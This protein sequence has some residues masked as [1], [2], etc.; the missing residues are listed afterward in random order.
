MPCAFNILANL[1]QSSTFT[2]IIDSST[3]NS[4]Y[5]LSNP[6]L[7][8]FREG[9]IFR[10]YYQSLTDNNPIQLLVGNIENI[11]ISY[12]L[13]GCIISF[14]VGYMTNILSR[15]QLV[16]T[17]SQQQITG[18]L[19]T[20]YAPQQVVF[21]DFLGELLSETYISQ[22]VGNT[23]YYGGQDE[24]IASGK[25]SPSN[26]TATSGSAINA[27]SYV[28]A[29]TPPTDSKLSVIL[30]ILY[31]YQRVIYVNTDGD[32]IIT[33]LTTFFDTNEDWT[34]GINGEP[35]IIP[36]LDISVSKNTTVIQN[37]SYC[38]MNQLFQQ[39]NQS[40]SSSVSN[41]ANTAVC[42]A[43]PP[44]DLFP[45]A[46]DFVQSALGL[47]TSFVIQAFDANAFMQNSGLLNTAYNLTTLSGVKSVL[48][49]NNENIG[50]DSNTPQNPLKYAMSL[51][52]VRDLAQ[53][54]VNDLLVDIDINTT[55]TYS[56]VLGRF[57][58]IPLNQMV[59][60]PV[61]NNNLYD[62][63]QQLFCYGFN[64][65]FSVEHGSITTLNLCKPYVFTAF[66]TPELV[67]I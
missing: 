64:L 33:P 4:K 46:Y 41:Q 62:K 36:C 30:Q 61:V 57:R 47:Q 5:N 1:K 23:L 32:L 17:Q 39:F 26:P 12:S 53:N 54:L 66:W 37:R 40:D 6:I 2:A 63:Q 48:N 7:D 59:S 38:S 43:T 55:N 16:Q 49:V 8:V 44:S 18:T 27:Q 45:R 35:D 22:T 19:L 20:A 60:Q 65:S 52:T 51:Y 3:T 28:F 14:S 34:L 21:G 29:V 42:V 50:Y 31:P 9:D 15:S 24:T 13:N 58:K 56:D 10:A 67:Q 25:A 11:H